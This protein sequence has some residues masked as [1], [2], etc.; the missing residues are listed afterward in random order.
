MD[1]SRG[2]I[3]RTILGYAVLRLRSQPK[4]ACGGGPLTVHFEKHEFSR[5]H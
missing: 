1:R 3:T 4:L 2:G 5:R